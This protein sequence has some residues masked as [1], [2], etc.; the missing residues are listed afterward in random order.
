MKDIRIGIFGTGG[1]AAK[2]VAALQNVPGVRVVA[3]CNRNEAKARAFNSIHLN[4]AAACYDRFDDML[5]RTPLDALYACIPPGAHDGEVEAAAAKGIHL[6]L[7]KPIALSLDRAESIAKAVRAAGV[8]CQIGHNFRHT[9]PALKLK[10]LIDDGSA[11]KPLLMQASWFTNRLHGDWWRDPTLGG[12]Q[13][14][15]QSIHL[16]DLARYFLGE[17]ADVVGFADRLGHGRFP[18]YRVDDTSAATVRFRS[19]AIASIC[20]S[21]CA[22]PWN[23]L[24]S[25]TIVCEKVFVQFKSPQDAVFLHHRGMV[26]E[27]A[28]KP[29]VERTCEDV[30]G[31]DNGLIEISRNFVAA[32]RSDELLR[33][34]V[35]DGLED[36]RLVLGVVTST[37]NGRLAHHL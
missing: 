12:G 36:L 29:G 9:V 16:Y 13:L 35:E 1:I 37:V 19:G 10:S 18:E 4:G 15:E 26:S 2:H 3:L 21:N 23:S 24:L 17:P 5:S 6:F 20:A 28:W 32:I 34:S 25:T 22:D 7:E 30:R 8:K 11:G 31:T 33:S 14:I 27:E